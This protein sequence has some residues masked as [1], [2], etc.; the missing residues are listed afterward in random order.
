[1]LEFECAALHSKLTRHPGAWRR[2]GFSP[3]LPRATW[4]RPNSGEFSTF[5][6]FPDL[7]QLQVDD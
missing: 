3:E 1:M 7:R 2:R 5:L 6:L 4:S